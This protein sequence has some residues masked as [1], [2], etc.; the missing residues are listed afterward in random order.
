MQAQQFLV[1]SLRA[2]GATPRLG[3]HGASIDQALA[4]VGDAAGS[5]FVLLDDVREWRTSQL[6]NPAALDDE[7][8]WRDVMQARPPEQAV[9]QT[10]ALGPFALP[11]NCAEP[12]PDGNWVAV[13]TD[14]M[15]VVLLPEAL[16]YRA[17][18]AASLE[19][20]PRTRRCAV[21]LTCR[22]RCGRP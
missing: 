13:L 9:A 7:E 20:D 14:R 22:V 21:A 18:A 3:S 8:V 16:D 1:Q 4:P 11:V 12:S 2:A 19:L 10:A 5:A 17:C 15:T 6:F